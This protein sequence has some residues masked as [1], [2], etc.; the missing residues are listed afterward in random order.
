MIQ[1]Y[2]GKRLVWSY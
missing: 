1:N 2:V